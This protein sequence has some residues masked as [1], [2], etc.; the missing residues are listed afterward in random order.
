MYSTGGDNDKDADGNVQALVHD[1][2]TCVDNYAPTFAWIVEDSDGNDI[3]Y[4]SNNPDN[5]FVVGK[6]IVPDDI[7]NYARTSSTG[8]GLW[9]IQYT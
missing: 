1:C 3:N 4:F 5:G 7:P 9:N 2:W 8:V 6:L